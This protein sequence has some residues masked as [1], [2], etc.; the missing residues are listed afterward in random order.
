MRAWQVVRYGAPTDALE[1]RQVPEPEPGQGEILVRTT[2]SVLNYN[3]VDGCHGRYLTINPPLPY[4]LG[5]ECVG[6]VVAAGSAAE[7]WVGRRVTA[8]GRGGTGAHADLV[9]G[10]TAMAFA[11]PDHAE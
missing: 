11:A 4:T 1:Q 6:E 2:A 3:E 8:S 9:A 5:M 10:S 7:G